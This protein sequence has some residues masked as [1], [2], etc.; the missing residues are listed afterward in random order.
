VAN[1]NLLTIAI[2]TFNRCEAVGEQIKY[3]LGGDLPKGIEILVID[4]ASEDGTYELL[5]NEINKLSPEQSNI[6]ILRNSKNIGF[7]G[8]FFKLFSECNTEYLLINSDED[9]IF[10]ENLKKILSFIA[11]KKPAFISPQALIDGK[12]YRGIE[13]VEPIY[14]KEHDAAS[15][16]ISGLI[17]NRDQSLEFVP[18][19]QQL[20]YQN[21]AAKFYP[22][23]MLA[24]CLSLSF[25][26][27]WLNI[28]ICEKKFDLSTQI[29]DQA[30]GYYHEIN[31]RVNQIKG[32]L[33]FLEDL[34][35]RPDF[36][37]KRSE[38]NL[39]KKVI[40]RS[41]FSTIR[42]ALSFDNKDLLYGFDA[43]ARS[44]YK[45]VPRIYGLCLKLYVS[46]QKKPRN[47]IRK[48]LK[49]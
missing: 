42:S 15:F 4:N 25:K 47:T 30:D 31:S 18:F 10:C 29:H 7:C 35:S 19:I 9:W 27:Y 46:L 24:A 5:K 6:R 49:K 11:D 33:N 43:G 39:Y 13:R 2:P 41:T 48:I 8:N 28:K 21:L 37:G 44:Y 45:I 3:L 26:C 23:V 36:I 12:I 34:G 38:I 20:S 40:L 1:R 14:F 17:F 22:Q 32:F 16:Y